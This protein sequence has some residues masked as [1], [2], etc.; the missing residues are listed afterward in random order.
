MELGRA[1][2]HFDRGLLRSQFCKSDKS[3]GYT[4]KKF[5]LIYLKL[6]WVQK[7]ISAMFIEK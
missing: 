6:I 2:V 3:L 5:S 7:R 1:L 4:G